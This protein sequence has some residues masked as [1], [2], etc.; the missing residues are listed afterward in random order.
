MLHGLVIS[1]FDDIHDLCT[2]YRLFF[3]VMTFIPVIINHSFGNIFQCYSLPYTVPISVC[4][5]SYLLV[6]ACW[7]VKTSWNGRVPVGALLIGSQANKLVSWEIR[8]SVRKPVLWGITCVWCNNFDNYLNWLVDDLN[9]EH[10]YHFFCALLLP[11]KGISE[12][13]KKKLWFY[14]GTAKHNDWKCF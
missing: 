4:S 6:S 5:P 12:K 2:L 14:S 3:S 7:W 11:N 9:C 13:K 10:D 1:G 8:G